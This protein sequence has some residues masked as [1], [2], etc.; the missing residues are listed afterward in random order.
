MTLCGF[1]HASLHANREYYCKRIYVQQVGNK[2]PHYIQ[3]TEL[4]FLLRRVQVCTIA[5][6]TVIA[7]P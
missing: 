2:N 5:V 6:S 4:H 3:I 1:V 7:V